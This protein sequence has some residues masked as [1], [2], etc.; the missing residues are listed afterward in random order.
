MP[1]VVRDPTVKGHD[2]NGQV[3]VITNKVRWNHPRR[4][5][6]PEP[7]GEISKGTIREPNDIAG[8]DGEP[9]AKSEPATHEFV[10]EKVR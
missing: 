9:E 3:L 7:E 5:L 6:R 4:L 2:A 8:R 1:I 10:R